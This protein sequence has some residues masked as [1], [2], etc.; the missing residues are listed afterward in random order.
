MEGS[1][2]SGLPLATSRE[3]AE[4]FITAELNRAAPEG[5]SVVHY[6]GLRW[7]VVQSEVPEG[8][9]VDED[10]GVWVTDGLDFI[11][12]THGNSDRG[13]FGLE[14]VLLN[15]LS[16]DAAALRH[17]GVPTCLTHVMSHC[18]TNTWGLT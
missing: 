5:W 8:E 13:P 9:W 1:L 12:F 10:Y 16:I 7:A 15:T 11:L 18:K 2:G 4:A 3:D 17:F 14:Q 6:G